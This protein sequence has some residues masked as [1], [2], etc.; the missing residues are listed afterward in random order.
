[1]RLISFQAQDGK[2]IGLISGDKVI[3][4]TAVDVNAPRD[5][6]SVIQDGSIASLQTIADKASDA[7]ILNYDDLQFNIP[8]SSPG[9]ILCLGLN[10]MEHVNEGIFEKQPFPTIFMRSKSSMVA[11]NEP[12][13]RPSV[14]ET[15]GYEVDP[16][17]IIGRISCNLTAENVL[18]V[19]D[20]YSCANHGSVREYQRHNIQWTMGKISTR[21]SR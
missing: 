7:K 13:I 20:G 2:R 3:D 16:A 12:I 6:Q 17:L 14:S 1:M 19:V 9:K 10:Y 15:L 8:I 5:I 11:H 4:L 18:D 21:Q